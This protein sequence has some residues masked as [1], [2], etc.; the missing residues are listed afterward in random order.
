MQVFEQQFRMPHA[1][2]ILQVQQEPVQ[3]PPHRVQPDLAQPADLIL[4]TE[5]NTPKR[6][7]LE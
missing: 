3:E 6:G 7:S 4:Q 1:P 5:Q 2:A